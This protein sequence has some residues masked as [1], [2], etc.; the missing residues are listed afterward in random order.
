MDKTKQVGFSQRIRIEWI[1]QT[2]ILLLKNMKASEIK[3]TL[4][5]YLN[6]KLSIGSNPERGAREKAITII[7]K[8]WVNPPKEFT[9]LRDDGLNFI[10]TLPSQEHTIINWTMIKAIYPFF[11][12]VAENVGR[13]L[14]LQ[15]TVSMAQVLRRV[16]EQFGERSTV[17]RATQRVVRSMVDWKILKDTNEKGVYALQQSMIVNNEQVI[18][19]LVEAFLLEN[20][21]KSASLDT[22]IKHPSLFPFEISFSRI[23][24][25]EKNRNIELIHQGYED[26]VVHKCL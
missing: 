23:I 11:G 20:N 22:I 17:I 2:A 12:I 10:K 15:G 14:K 7:M 21:L 8:I 26:I 1:E 9:K 4:R 18:A 3:E 6:N 24:D 16:T 5:D 19:W 25:F 13:L